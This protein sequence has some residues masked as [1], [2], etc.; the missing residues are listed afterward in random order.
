LLRGVANQRLEIGSGQEDVI[1]GELWAEA[2]DRMMVRIDDTA[3]QVREGFPLHADPE[4]GKWTASPDGDWTGGFWNGMLWLAH[5]TTGEQRHLDWAERW[6]DLLRP[7]ARSENIFRSFLFYYGAA[8][9]DILVGNSQAREVGLLGAR[10][11]ATLYNTNARAIPLG[12]EA[13]AVSDVDVGPG[14]ANVDGVQATALLIWAAKESG[15]Q[16]LYEIGIQHALRFIEFCVRDDG[17]VIQSV[18]FDTESG[19]VIKHYTHKG[20]T[21]D[22]TWARAQAWAM[23]GYSVSAIW[24]PNRQVFVDTAMR[25]ADWWIDH[26]PSDEVAFWDF[27]APATAAT[28]RDT[29]ATAI[30]AAALLKLSA[31]APSGESRRYYWEAAEAT[32][33]TLVEDYLT[34]IVSE[35][36]RTPGILTSGCY[37]HRTGLATQNELIWGDYYLFESL[38]VLAGNLDPTAL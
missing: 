21:D 25:T 3:A 36:G 1:S 34:P 14:D 28:K 23:L 20:F 5:T 17:S 31:L 37:N 22:S 4:T 7:R 24:E 18:R 8:L 29:S 35:D 6:T 27:N 16:S 33:R 26:V 9:G 32:V 12:S 30:A 10:G 15:D 19:E 2:I 13:E 11:L 38:Q